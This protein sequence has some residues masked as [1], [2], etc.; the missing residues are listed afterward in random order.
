MASKTPKGD[1]HRDDATSSRAFLK[2]SNKCIRRESESLGMESLN[3]LSN[4]V[5]KELNHA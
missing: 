5:R 1:W 3:T 4:S 2:D